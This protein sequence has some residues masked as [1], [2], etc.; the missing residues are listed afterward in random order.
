M[1]QAF[2]C[3]SAFMHQCSGLDR[4]SC[5]YFHSLSLTGPSW[6]NPGTA[7]CMACWPRRADLEILCATS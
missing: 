5:W 2:L 4:D 3:L 7:W 6:H 1:E